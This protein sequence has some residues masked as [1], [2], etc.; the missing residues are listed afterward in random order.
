MKFSN[1]AAM[2]R[3]GMGCVYNKL[4]TSRELTASTSLKRG[5]NT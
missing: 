5:C 4:P 3:G 2:W 1:I